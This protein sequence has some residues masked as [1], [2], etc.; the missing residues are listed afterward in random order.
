[1]EKN[2]NKYHTQSLFSLFLFLLIIELSRYKMD[3]SFQYFLT[4]YTAS[5]FFVD[6]CFGPAIKMNTSYKSI[7]ES[8]TLPISL[9]YQVDLVE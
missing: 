5:P 1:M 4:R 9:F 3:F 8:C 7:W 2:S 6:L